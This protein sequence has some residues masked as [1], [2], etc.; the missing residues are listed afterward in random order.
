MAT[1]YECAGWEQD[2]E[3][4]EESED[5]YRPHRGRRP[6]GRRGR[7]PHQG[8]R[9]PETRRTSTFGGDEPRS[10]RARFVSAIRIT[11]LGG[12]FMPE[13]GIMSDVL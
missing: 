9:G 5:T 3:V 12:Y 2:N 4:S 8:L 13:H 10:M 6:H 7:Q 1:R 11:P